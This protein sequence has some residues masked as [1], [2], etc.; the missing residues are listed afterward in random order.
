MSGLSLDSQ[1]NLFGTTYYGG[2]NYADRDGKGAGTIFRLSPLGGYRVMHNFC[3]VYLCADGEYPKAGV[4][5]DGNGH[6]FGTTQLGGKY[7]S[8]FQGGTAFRVND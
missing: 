2:Y 1:G 4:L 3:S 6:L 8:Y 7:T 5:M